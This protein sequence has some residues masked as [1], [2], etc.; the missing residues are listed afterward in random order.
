MTG[1][2]KKISYATMRRLTHIFFVMTYP[3]LIRQKRIA[4][5]SLAIAFGGK[6]DK[7]E[8]DKIFHDCFWN[9]ASGMMELM[10]YMEHPEWISRMA[11]F[12]GKEHLDAALRQGKGAIAVS[13]HFGNFPLMLLRCVQEGYKTNAIIRPTRDQ[14]IEKY[15]FN[16]RTQLGLNTVYSMPRKQCVDTSLRV[17]RNNEILFIPLDQN[18]GSQGGVFVD[19]FGQKAATA[20]GPVIFAMRTKAPIIPMFVIREKDDRHRIIVEPPL[21][22]EY[23]ENDRETLEVNTARI[24]QLIERYIRRY[25]QEW[26]WMHRR[27]KH[28]P[29]PAETVKT[30]ATTQEVTL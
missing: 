19:F 29:M 15:F 10:Y 13:A 18:F 22:L 20:T 23:K 21:E 26:G 3:F 25:P 16:L 4:A 2:I 7:K 9:V 28:Q 24:T 11:Y 6:K 27:W 14:E 30:A 8:V 17:L 12:E 1:I 5:E